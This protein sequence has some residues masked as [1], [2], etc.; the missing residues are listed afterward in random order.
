MVP[1]P[2]PKEPLRPQFT[3]LQE[4]NSNF[5]E[6]FPGS[7]GARQTA[8]NSAVIPDSSILVTSANWVTP[9]KDRPARHDCVNAT[10]N[11]GI[12]FLSDVARSHADWFSKNLVSIESPGFAARKGTPFVRRVQVSVYVLPGARVRIASFIAMPSKF[13]S[14]TLNKLGSKLGPVHHHRIA[15]EIMMTDATTSRRR[16]IFLDIKS[17][18]FSIVN[19]PVMLWAVTVVAPLRCHFECR[20]RAR[21]SYR[22]RSGYSALSHRKAKR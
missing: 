2:K 8:R 6:Y 11:A 18:A 7:V 1:E 3:I 9:G 13:N 19:K 4:T 22:H 15:G 12:C 21:R 10:T 17:S 14:E 5:N 16:H 20:Q